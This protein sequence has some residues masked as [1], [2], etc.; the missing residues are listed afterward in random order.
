MMMVD[1][2][3]A[4]KITKTVN[5]Y[6]IR[7]QEQIGIV[8]D[9]EDDAYTLYLHTEKQNKHLFGFFIFIILA[10]H[11]QFAVAPKVFSFELFRLCFC[12][13]VYYMKRSCV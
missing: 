8:A 2:S 10:V 13:G 6:N 7:I 1:S 11:M 12:I 3:L 5:P 9:V 4:T